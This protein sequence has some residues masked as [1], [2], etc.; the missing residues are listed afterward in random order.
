MLKKYF[1]LT[2]VACLAVGIN[3]KAQSFENFLTDSVSS[4][5]HGK[6]F[7]L[8]TAVNFGR[9][10]DRGNSALDYSGVFTSTAASWYI[11][12]PKSD[13]E[14]TFGGST[15]QLVAKAQSGTYAQSYNAV[16]LSAYKLYSVYTAKDLQIK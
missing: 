2:L 6:Y 16:A 1:L 5:V 14:L 3:L 8:S 10:R 12:K 11:S 15:G 9:L 7:K 13:F 4:L